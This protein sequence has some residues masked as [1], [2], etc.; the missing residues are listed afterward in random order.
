M[1][2]VGRGAARVNSPTQ[3]AHVHDT[4]LSH[5][6]INESKE[7]HCQNDVPFYLIPK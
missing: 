7:I 5:N 4:F 2:V 3:K 6:G 1:H